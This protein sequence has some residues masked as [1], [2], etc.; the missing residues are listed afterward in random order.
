MLGPAP[1]PPHGS[2]VVPCA[3]TAPGRPAAKSA[4]HDRERDEREA[5]DEKG[6]FG[7]L[8]SDEGFHRWY[9]ESNAGDCE[10]KG[11]KLLHRLHSR[12]QMPLWLV[13]MPQLYSKRRQGITG[14]G[15]STAKHAAPC[16]VPTPN[17]ALPLNAVVL[18]HRPRTESGSK[19]P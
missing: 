14:V 9:Q 13:V 12:S 1:R 11:D 4:K 6:G 7:R 10:Q 2:S 16:P 15:A 3:G 17:I 18:P 8:P 5:D 19:S